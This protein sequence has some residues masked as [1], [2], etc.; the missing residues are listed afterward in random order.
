MSAFENKSLKNVTLKST[1]THQCSTSETVK[2]NSYLTSPSIHN[3]ITSDH[4]INT[5]YEVYVT[6][7]H[8]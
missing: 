1:T 4:S 5:T 2:S 8:N 3:D 6:S 7:I